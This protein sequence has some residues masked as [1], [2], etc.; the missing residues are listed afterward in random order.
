MPD[1]CDL[2]LKD[3]QPSQF[4]ISERKLRGV[5]EWFRPEDLEIG[6]KCIKK[7]VVKKWGTFVSSEVLLFLSFH[8]C[9]IV[10]AKFLRI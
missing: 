9:R 7:S 1:I 6:F 5:N 4:Y 8:S 3:L 2:Q 10:L